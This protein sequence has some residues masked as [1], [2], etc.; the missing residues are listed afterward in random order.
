MAGSELAGH[1]LAMKPL[2]DATAVAA[3]LGIGRAAAYC[4]MKG[5]SRGRFRFLSK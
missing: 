5:A 4:E 3:L 1:T 2:L